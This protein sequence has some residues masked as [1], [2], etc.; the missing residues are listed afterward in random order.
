[1]C[2]LHHPPAGPPVPVPFHLPDLLASTAD[3]DHE[4]AF[5]KNL[6]DLGAIVAFDEAE[7]L[8]GR[9]GRKNRVAFEC[10][11]KELVVD[12]IGRPKGESN[13]DARRL[14]EE[15]TLGSALGSAGGVGPGGFATERLLGHGTIHR[16]PGP[17]E[18]NDIIVLE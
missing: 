15:A 17:P 18:N 4:L 8:R 1:M 12:P 9:I 3:G 11:S 7:V 16:S 5:L 2:S 10:L 14:R 6:G 13:G